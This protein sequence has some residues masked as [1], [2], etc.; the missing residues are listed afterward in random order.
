M[1]YPAASSARTATHPTDAATTQ[2]PE[3]R[4]TDWAV[5]AGDPAPEAGRSS[6]LGAAHALDILSVGASAPAPAWS[7]ATRHVAS[8]PTS[9]YAR[10]TARAPARSSTPS[11]AALIATAAPTL[12]S[13]R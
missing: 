13:A 7:F 8:A 4:G 11:P 3:A 2:T 5:A 6:S 9:G 12:A 1:G 10:P